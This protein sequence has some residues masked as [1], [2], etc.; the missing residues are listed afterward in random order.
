MLSPFS[1]PQ[2]A[3][4]ESPGLTCNFR[5]ANFGGMPS[6]IAHYLVLACSILLA[7]PHGWCC[8]LKPTTTDRTS[9]CVSCARKV[10]CKRARTC[11]CCSQG[12]SAE[13]CKLQGASLPP[14]FRCPCE[15]R[16]ATR[17]Q[18]VFVDCDTFSIALCLPPAI[19]T[20]SC[21]LTALVPETTRPPPA[22]PVHLLN[23]VWLC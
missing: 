20:I 6:R 5:L 4:P 1:P 23:C 21:D 10:A 7:L 11:S 19:T 3:V 15:D 16:N 8:L 22:S 9:G 14:R 18:K 2:L 17:L 12:T 13:E